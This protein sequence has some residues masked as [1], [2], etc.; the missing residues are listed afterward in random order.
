MALNY[1]IQQRKNPRD[2]EGLPKYYIV[3]SSLSAISFEDLIIEASE[4]TT[5]NPDELRLGLNLLFKKAVDRLSEGHTVDMGKIGRMGLRVNS[6]GS[7]TE[8]EV[9]V[10]GNVKDIK[11]YFVFSDEIRAKLKKTKLKKKD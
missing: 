9:S 4:E 7:D 6:S 10:A 2:P 1:T 5:L 3:S 8:A 11:P